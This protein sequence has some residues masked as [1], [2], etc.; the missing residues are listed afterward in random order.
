MSIY[1]NQ[2]D[3]QPD[4]SEYIELYQALDK[5]PIKLKTVVL[6]RFFE[7]MKLEEIAQITGVNLSTVKSRAL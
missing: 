1:T 6:L 2:N 4:I 5:L 3:P 7:D